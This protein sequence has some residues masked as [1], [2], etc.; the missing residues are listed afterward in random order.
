[1]ADENVTKI[2]GQTQEVKKVVGPKASL[3]ECYRCGKTNHKA[4]V[5]FHKDTECNGCHK[6]GHLR[7]MCRMENHTTANRNWKYGRQGRKRSTVNMAEEKTS[8]SE[9]ETTEC[10][11]Q[12]E[13]MHTLK[14]CVKKMKA[15]HNK[16]PEIIVK[17]KL[18]G[19]PI[20]MELDTG[21]SVSLISEEFYAKHLKNTV[22]QSSDIVLKTMTGEKIEVVGICYVTMEVHGHRVEEVPLYVVQGNGPALFGRDWLHFAKFDWK[23]LAVNHLHSG[24]LKTSK[25]EELLRKYGDVF[26]G[27]LGT[28]KNIKA[29]IRVRKDAKPIFY[30]AR[31][32]P[33]AIRDAV[34]AELKRLEL[35]GI[36]EKVDYSEWAAPIVPVSKDNGS[37]RICGDFKVTINRYVENP[38]HPMPNPD[39]LYQRLNGGKTF[40]KLDLSQAYQQVELDEE[41]RKY[42]TINTPLGLYRYTRLPYGVSAAPQLFQS[43]MDKVLQGVPCGCNIDDISLTGRTEAEHLHNLEKVLERLHINGLKCNL[44]KC[45]FMKPSLKYLSFI[46]DEEGIHMTED[47]IAAVTEAPRPESRS[48]MQSFLGLV[49]HYRRYVPNLSSVAAPLTEL[50]HKD[51]KWHWSV[52]CERAFSEIKKMLTTETGVLVHYDLS[53]PVTLAVDA[54]PKGLGAVLSHITNNKPLSY[55]LGPRKGIPV[56]AAARIQRWAIQLA[57]YDYDI[58]LRRS[59]DNGNADALSRLPLPDCDSDASDKHVN[60]T[61]EATAFN[62]HQVN[63]LPVTAKSVARETLHDAVLARA[64]YYTRNGWPDSED[65]AQELKPFHSRQ[66][67][68]SIEEGCLLWGARVVIPSRYR[69]QIL[70]ELHGGHPGIVRM[71]GLARLHVWW[72]NIDQDI[73]NTVQGCSACQATQPMPTRAEG[74]PWKWPSGPW[75]R[76]HVDFAGPFL[77]K[78]TSL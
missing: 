41:S 76:V 17:V 12:D 39:E 67:E 62:M 75:K 31:T 34:N 9:E 74:N 63:S 20:D 72:P 5:C 68:F 60:W 14:Y 26:D 66:R 7:R 52:E 6:K 53:K 11:L 42:V 55:I 10:K 15:R 32:V 8:G 25:L 61:Q 13:L 30:K 51:R 43:L 48:E 16:V 2:Q 49:N 59:S 28:A 77:D 24:I 40:S 38:E 29:H 33:Y 57:A 21:A 36:I 46:V 22:L 56:L 4:D 64:L 3:L 19:I 37:I 27:E 69:I 78:C 73:E 18:N 54:S 23:K 50:L 1:M 70:E 65:I 58:E 44:S 35:E 47:A 71:K 45:E